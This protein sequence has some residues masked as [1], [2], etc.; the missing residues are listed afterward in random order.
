MAKLYL[1]AIGGTGS[2]VLR[3]LTMMM[4]AGVKM[5]V[6]EVVPIIIDPDASNQNLTDTVQLMNEY[7]ETR[8][9]LSFPQGVETQFFRTELSQILPNYTLRIQNTNNKKFKQF[10]DYSSVQSTSTKAMLKM[11]FS[12]KNLDSS[13]D[14]GF[15]GNPNIGSVVL[16]QIV[17]SGDFTEFANNFSAGDKIFIISSIFG[18]TGASGFPLLLK[19]LRTNTVMP[20]N[21][22]INNAEIGAITM[23]PYFKLAQSTESEIDS[24]TFISKTKSALAYYE[25]N[26]IENN[27]INALYYLADDVTN[28]YDNNE[29]GSKQRN[30]AHLIEFLA[31]TAVADFCN[32]SYQSG[33][34]VN[35]E[36]GIKDIKGGVTFSSFDDSLQ[37]LLFAPLTE[38]ILMTNYLTRKESYY[39]SKSFN[40]NNDN[41]KD[42]YNSSFFTVLKSMCF[43]YLK[44]LEEMKNN[45]RSLDLFDLSSADKPFDV[46]TGRKPKKIFSTKSD[47]DLVTDRLNSAAKHCNSKSDNDKFLEMFFLGTQKLLKEKFN[48]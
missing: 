8:K 31:A 10:I 39:S 37:K 13:M 17:A 29:G 41:F 7:R 16:N 40:A 36:L 44:W 23:L 47:Y 35:K 15:K 5:D 34:T 45:K 3:S 11:L 27:S 12:E 32:N 38:Y 30:D 4:A 24:S 43:S 21:E 19:T 18:G 20:N 14:V 28:T 33:A 2:R 22:L 9:D 1:F 25:N 46:V 26:I 42:L 48:A 6:D